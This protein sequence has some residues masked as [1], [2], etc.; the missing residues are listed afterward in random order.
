[1]AEGDTIASPENLRRAAFDRAVTRNTVDRAQRFRELGF[2]VQFDPNDP[3]S[4][5]KSFSNDPFSQAGQLFQAETD[6]ARNAQTQGFF[7]SG[8][9]VGQGGLFNQASA[10]VRRSGD[11]GRLN[12]EKQFATTQAQ[13]LSANREERDALDADLAAFDIEESL[14]QEFD[15]FESP[16]EVDNPDV[17][18]SG[19]GVSFKV[20]GKV[21][22]FNTKQSLIKFLKARGKSP[23]QWVKNHP[24]AARQLGFKVKGDNTSGNPGAEHRSQEFTGGGKNVGPRRGQ[25]SKSGKRLT[26]EQI[27]R[28]NKAHPKS[29]RFR[30]DGR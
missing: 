18:A 15:P 24:E 7:Q 28:F 19:K 9:G 22:N 2:D 8:Q 14:S 16:E 13:F 17:P 3:N 12:L 27:R 25:F 26:G 30:G 4:F 21:K 11:L 10:D 29:R 23:K 5:N 1:M 20:G 6:Q